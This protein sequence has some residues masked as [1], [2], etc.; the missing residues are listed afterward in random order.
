MPT[1][2]TIKW[3]TWH[4]N[5]QRQDLPTAKIELTLKDNQESLYWTIPFLTQFSLR[6]TNEAQ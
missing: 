1:K 5:K 3:K 6:Q 4:W 2:Q